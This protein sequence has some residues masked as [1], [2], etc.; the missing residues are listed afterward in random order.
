MKSSS[1]LHEA[2]LGADTQSTIVALDVSSPKTDHQ[3]FVQRSPGAEIA[4]KKIKGKR[5]QVLR[6]LHGAARVLATGA[7]TKTVA[8]AGKQEDHF[9]RCLLLSGE[10]LHGAHL[11]YSPRLPVSKDDLTSA[12]ALKE[13]SE[14]A[15]SVVKAC[16]GWV[17]HQD[18]DEGQE[19]VGSREGSLRAP[20]LLPS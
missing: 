20:S 6:V 1:V 17:D 15:D 19:R 2:I 4:T 9:V 11:G 5:E 8:V 18:L 13:V 3:V 14:A 12:V 16:V 7:V 10:P